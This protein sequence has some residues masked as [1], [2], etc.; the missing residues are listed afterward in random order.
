M[1][2]VR[3]TVHTS[4]AWAFALAYMGLIYYVSS[5]SVLPIPMTYLYQDKVMHAGAYF[6]LACLLAHAYSKGGLKRRFLL[7]F[8]LAALY[9]AS[10]EIHQLFVPGRDCSIWDWAADGVGAWLGAFLYLRTE[11]SLYRWRKPAK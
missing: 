1:N 5:L 6:V 11:H 8:V 4:L 7:A 3:G 10:D 9:G 2:P